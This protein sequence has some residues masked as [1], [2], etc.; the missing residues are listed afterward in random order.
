MA[1][2]ARSW[3]KHLVYIR[4]YDSSLLPREVGTVI[5]AWIDGKPGLKEAR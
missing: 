3:V 5:T 4:A 1:P 2:Q